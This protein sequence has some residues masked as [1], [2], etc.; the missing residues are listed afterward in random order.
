[1]ITKMHRTIVVDEKQKNNERDTVHS[2]DSTF[3]HLNILTRR[4]IHWLISRDLFFFLFFINLYWLCNVNRMGGK[5]GRN[6]QPK[7]KMKPSMFLFVV[8]LLTP[9]WNYCARDQIAFKWILLPI[10]EW[11]FLRKN[12]VYKADWNSE[13]VVWTFE[14]FTFLV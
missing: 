9:R 14:E 8:P 1:M 4:A 6:F 12:V 11:T 13:I 5:N 7:R 2:M 10:N 3:K